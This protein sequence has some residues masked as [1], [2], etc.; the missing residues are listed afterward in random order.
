MEYMKREYEINGIGKTC[1]VGL[2]FNFLPYSE[3]SFKELFYKTKKDI[4]A[5]T[6][7]LNC[8]CNG[9]TTFV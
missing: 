7:T 2:K 1:G 5:E 6:S 9:A 3:K 4:K 8:Y